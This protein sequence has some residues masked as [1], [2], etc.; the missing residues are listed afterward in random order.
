MINDKYWIWLQKS[1]GEGAYFKEI[2]DD[3]GS[4]E[5]LYNSNILERRM[6]TALTSKQIDQLEKYTIDDSQ[7]IIDDCSKNNWQI[8]TY[9]DKN[10]PERLKNISNPPAVLYVDG[11]L[12]D[13]DNAVLIGIV[14]TR[15]ASTY[16][17]KVA[18]IMSKGISLCGA[19]AVS[20]GALGVDSAAHKG[21]IAVGAKN[22]AVL[23]NGF[24]ADYLKGNQDLRS[25]IKQNGALVSEY[26]PYTPATKFTFPMRNRII[27]GLS[28]GVFVVEA[29]VKSG[30]LITAKYANEQGR[31]IYAIPA[32]IFDYDY[33]GTN[34]LID[35]GATVAT[36]PK[37]LIERYAEE[38]KSI[39]LSKIKTVR[40]LLEET[41]DKSANAPKEQQVTFDKI[42]SD[43]AK[44]VDRQNKVI[45]LSNEEKAVYNVLSESFVGIDVV[46]DKSP[47]ISR[48]TVAM[49]TTLEM[50]GLIE[51]ASGKRYKIK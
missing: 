43:R 15:K 8:V 6:S 32:S 37:I 14:G 13:V 20:G 41:I 1:L 49:L 24:G 31:D 18:H 23:G 50:K 25:E 4:I 12:P 3:F 9:E 45:E 29:G 42:E 17:L 26:P 22:I 38:Y 28:L 47:L 7:K 34:K 40:E 51:V 39:D 44:S 10:Y 2:I 16:A 5:N 19:V 11:T 36:S 33:Y 46:I 21:A 27:S 48:R 35:D 30:S